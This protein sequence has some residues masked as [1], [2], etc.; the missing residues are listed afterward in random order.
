MS[1]R[2]EQTVKVVGVDI[3]GTKIAAGYLD[4]DGTPVQLGTAPTLPF[5]GAANAAAVR[6]LIDDPR[7]ADAAILGVSVATTFDHDDRLR[8]PRG[9]F[10]WPGENLAEVL[11]TA[12]R[13]AV[14]IADAAAGAMGEYLHGEGQGCGH[15]LYLTV[16]TGIS[17]CLVIDGKPVGGAHN[18]AYFSGYTP[19][20][21]CSGDE[22]DFA[23]VEAISAGPALARAYGGPDAHDARPVFAAAATGEERAVDVVEHAAWH[24][25]ALMATLLSIYDP[26]LLVVGGGLGTGVDAYR[27]RAIE[28]A[29]EL[30]TTEHAR[31]I[32]IVPA[33]LRS[34][35]CWV[36]A[37]GMASTVSVPQPA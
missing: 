14:I 2:T 28:V 21:R 3:G 33:A 8:D 20:A 19:Q 35:S 34:E 6:R 11:G 15:L 32:P 13:P 16:G 1:S 10:G 37:I 26:G 24:L 31:A 7:V 27:D 22:C 9:W 30:V 4:A 18:A 17:H 29:R 12:E 23:H 25:G 36:G 5:D